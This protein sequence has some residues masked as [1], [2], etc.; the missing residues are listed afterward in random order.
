MGGWENG[1]DEDLVIKALDQLRSAEI[2]LGLVENQ[3]P[4]LGKHP[5]YGLALVQLLDAIRIL[6]KA[7]S[8]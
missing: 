2:N 8:E 5:I 4:L 3:H 6:D 1:V 7:T